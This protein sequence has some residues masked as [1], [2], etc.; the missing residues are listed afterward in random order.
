MGHGFDYPDRPY[1]RDHLECVRPKKQ[2]GGLLDNGIKRRFTKF[3]DECA[4]LIRT[5]IARTT[6]PEALS[7]RTAAL[8]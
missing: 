2:K 4:G 5:C 6:K 8:V 7:C 1:P 3:L